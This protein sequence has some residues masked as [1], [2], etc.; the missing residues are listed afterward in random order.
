VTLSFVIESGRFIRDVSEKVGDNSESVTNASFTSTLNRKVSWVNV[1]KVNKPTGN[2]TIYSSFEQETS[3][4]AIKPRSI[5]NLVKLN[6]IFPM[7]KNS[8]FI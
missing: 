7:N 4:E 2:C 1:V 5:I 3:N 8:G 6:F